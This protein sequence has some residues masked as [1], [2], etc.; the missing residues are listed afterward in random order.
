MTNLRPFTFRQFS[1]LG[2][3]FEPTTAY[4][5]ATSSVREALTQSKPLPTTR[6]PMLHAW[7]SKAGLDDSRVLIVG[8]I[9]VDAWSWQQ[10]KRFCHQTQ[11]KQK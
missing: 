2:K 8:K 6:T 10:H 11:G 1:A 9:A 3:C 4:P 5:A 7:V